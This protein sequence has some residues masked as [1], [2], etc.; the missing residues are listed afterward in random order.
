METSSFNQPFNLEIDACVDKAIEV[1]VGMF[2]GK[3]I[4]IDEKFRNSEV[5][6]GW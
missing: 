1:G 4:R 3:G 5:Y 2:Q 6:L